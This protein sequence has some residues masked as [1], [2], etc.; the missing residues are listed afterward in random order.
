MMSVPRCTNPSGSW[1]CSMF[2]REPVPRFATQITLLPPFSSS[3]HRCDPRKPAPPVTKQVDIAAGYPAGM[4]QTDEHLTVA[5]IVGPEDPRRF[6]DSG[7]E[8][9]ELYTEGDPH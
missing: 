8:L 3:S 2:A 6:T 5:P 7:I 9:A 1:M 4:T